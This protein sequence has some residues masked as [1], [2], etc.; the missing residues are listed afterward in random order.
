MA[1]TL[2]RLHP[3][4]DEGGHIGH[5]ANERIVCIDPD[6]EIR[7]HWALGV[8]PPAAVGSAEIACAFE[9]ACMAIFGEP[10]GAGFTIVTGVTRPRRK[11]NTDRKPI[12][13]HLLKWLAWVMH[14]DNPRA[15]G[16]AM[17]AMKLA[18]P[19]GVDL[20]VAGAAIAE[21]R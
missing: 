3:P 7:K 16:A 10:W 14:F 5:T 2:H 11:F 20:A 15:V 4:S 9:D 19:G 21:A 17:V 6:G 18:E 1:F 13:P 8:A 12:P